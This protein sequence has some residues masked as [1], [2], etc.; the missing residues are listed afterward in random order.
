MNNKKLINSCNWSSNVRECLPMPPAARQS[1][2]FHTRTRHFSL[3]KY[4][5]IPPTPFC[6]PLS[7]SVLYIQ[8]TFKLLSN[9]HSPKLEP[10]LLLSNFCSFFFLCLVPTSKTKPSFAG[11]YKLSDLHL[12]LQ[13]STSKH[14]SAPY[15]ISKQCQTKIKVPKQKYNLNGTPIRKFPLF[16]TQL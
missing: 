16:E 14:L 3:T 10:S 5:S 15:L 8:A 9:T 11:Q 7:Q 12:F 6:L 4:V 2:H 1:L 13:P